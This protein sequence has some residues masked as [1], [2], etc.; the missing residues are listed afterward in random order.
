MGQVS[1]HWRTGTRA[2]TSRAAW[3]VIRRLLS[4]LESSSALLTPPRCCL[5]ASGPIVTGGL[6]SRSDRRNPGGRG[7][8]PLS[9]PDGS[10]IWR[11]GEPDRR[12]RWAA[13]GSF[14]ASSG[15]I[16][17][18]GCTNTTPGLESCALDVAGDSL[19]ASMVLSALPLANPVPEPATMLLMGT[20][21]VG[22]AA[23]KFRRKA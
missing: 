14:D 20:A 3:A 4:R 15:S 16:V 12:P 7:A 11:V 17:A 13:F 22:L 21:L 1:T 10:A 5:H 18:Q 9:L 23:M 6:G 2:L 8:E 19:S